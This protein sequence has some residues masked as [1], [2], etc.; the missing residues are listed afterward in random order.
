MRAGP[1]TEIH[2]TNRQRD[3]RVDTRALRALAEAV[4]AEA[5]QGAELGIHLV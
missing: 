2:F 5:G 4:L 3:R 1:Q